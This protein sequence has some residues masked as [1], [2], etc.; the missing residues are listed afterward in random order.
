[1]IWQSKQCKDGRKEQ[2]HLRVSVGWLGWVGL[3]VWVFYALASATLGRS[4]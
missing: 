4:G 2:A 1:M 3:H